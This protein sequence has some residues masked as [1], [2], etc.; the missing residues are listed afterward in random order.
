MANRS[1]RQ[2]KKATNC[3]G[4]SVGQMAPFRTAKSGADGRF[5]MERPDNFHTLMAMDARTC[6]R[7]IGGNS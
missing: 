5:S 3:S 2:L 6:A 1:T 4:V 7:W